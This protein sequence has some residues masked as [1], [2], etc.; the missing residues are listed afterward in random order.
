[1]TVVA[2]VSPAFN[3]KTQPRRLPPQKTGEIIC[4]PGKDRRSLSFCPEPSRRFS[5]RT[6]RPI[7]CGREISR[8]TSSHRAR[9]LARKFRGEVSCR[10]VC[11]DNRPLLSRTRS[12]Y[13]PR[14]RQPRRSRNNRRRNRSDARNKSRRLCSDRSAEKLF[15]ELDSKSLRNRRAHFP[16]AR[17]AM[18]DRETRT[19]IAADKKRRRSLSWPSSLFG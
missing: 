17:R 2:G 19:Q 7:V 5:S 18:R 3:G 10:L 14:S 13:Q 9:R 6:A 16:D 11:R 1:M 12:P 8:S 15:Q 4:F